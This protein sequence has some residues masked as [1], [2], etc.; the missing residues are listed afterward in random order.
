V[1]IDWTAKD[2][3]VSLQLRDEDGEVAAQAKVPLSKLQQKVDAKP[4][5]GKPV[6]GEKEK[7]KPKVKL[8]E[9]V[10]TPEQ[11]LKGKKGDDVT[12]QMEVVSGN[13]VSGGKR[14]LLNSIKD[15]RSDDCF[16]IV[17]N[18][19]AMTGDLDKATFDTFKGKTVRVKGKLSEF[20]MK[21]QIQVDDPKAVEFVEEK[22]DDKK[23]EDK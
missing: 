15:F 19:K 23:K 22:K 12:V 3:L 14:I 21:L 8:P 20:K 6:D 10:I 7:D 16:T 1:Q 17:I 11:A 2:P 4:T 18:E 13:A 5:G 9:G